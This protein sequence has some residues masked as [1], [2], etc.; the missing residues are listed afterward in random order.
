MTQFTRVVNGQTELRADLF[1]DL[2]EAIEGQAF[3]V[4]TY[5]AVGDGVT[6]DTAA[7]QAAWLA[8]HASLTDSP[9][10]DGVAGTLY[11]PPGEYVYTGTGL[12]LTAST[13]FRIAGAGRELSVISLGASSRLVN[14]TSALITHGSISGLQTVGGKGLFRHARTSDNTQGPLTFR[15][16]EILD[17]TEC[18]IGTM[19]SDYP[20]WLIE[21]VHFRGEP[22]TAIGVAHAGDAS[23]SVISHCSFDADLYHVKLGYGGLGWRITDSSFI[24]LI[25]PGSGGTTDIWIVP[26]AEYLNAGVGFTCTGNKFGNENLTAADY[27]I[28]F[29]DQ[30][31]GTDFLNKVH[32]ASASAGYV[33]RHVFTQNSVQYNT[34][35]AAV[36]LVYSTTDLVSS[37]YYG[38][39]QGEID[40]ALGLLS[41]TASDRVEDTNIWGPFYTDYIGREQ[42]LAGQPVPNGYGRYIDFESSRQ[43]ATSAVRQWESGADIGHAAVLTT[44]MASYNTS[45]AAITGAQADA[46]GTTN[47]IDV[48]FSAAAGFV[49]AEFTPPAAG[50]PHWIEFDLKVA[51]A[52]ALTQIAV[53]VWGG[54]TPIYFQRFLAVPTAW[55]H[56]RYVF[57]PRVATAINLVFYPTAAHYAAVTT[58]RVLIGSARIYAARE[59]VNTGPIH[60]GTGAARIYT[61]TGDPENAVTATVGSLYSRTDGGASTTLYIK[62]TGSTATGWR[63][64]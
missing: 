33:T 15:D 63:A 9:W 44:A 28:L 20:Y 26:K 25:T 7:I 54:P 53:G 41:G 50:V 21:N 6:D 36:P 18:A 23:G 29:A 16:L 1:N 40:I 47:A 4:V 27:R 10:F 61:G 51:P 60:L 58:D 24:R 19:S 8:A 42:A 17:Y 64:V 55:R 34:P 43:G 11:F 22:D 2:Q 59:P 30:G 5:G 57:V 62:E 46:Q 49:Y 31:T 45:N 52:A 37:C 32:S 35:A 14:V 3:S 12:D 38:D 48:D 56:Y 39:C 13:S